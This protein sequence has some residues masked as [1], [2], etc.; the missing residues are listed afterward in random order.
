[1]SDHMK[2]SLMTTRAIGI[3]N[4]N[5]I[6]DNNN[7]RSFE[8]QWSFLFYLTRFDGKVSDNATWT[9]M[10]IRYTCPSLADEVM[11]LYIHKMLRIN[12]RIFPT[13]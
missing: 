3:E 5:F 9:F 1:M 2:I 4:L 13:F 6:Q 8:M 7:L 11:F 10:G 12:T